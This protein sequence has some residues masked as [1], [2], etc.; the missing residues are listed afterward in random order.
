MDM[1]VEN[2]PNKQ[3]YHTFRVEILT[4]IA[5]KMDI[6]PLLNDTEDFTSLG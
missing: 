6:D 2:I 1:G 4:V 3:S 5:N